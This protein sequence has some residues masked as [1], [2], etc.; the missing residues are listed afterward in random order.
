VAFFD[1]D[2]DGWLDILVLNGSRLDASA[3]PPG[4]SNRLYRN[5]RDGTFTDVTEKAG[6]TR[7]GWAQGVTIGDYNNDGHED[8][9]ITYYG[10]NV[11]YR[12]N[13]DGT[14]T[15]VTKEA[16][17]LH[18]GT[19]WGSGCT[20]IDYN[21]DGHLDLFVANYVDFDVKR[22]GRPGANRG[23]TYKTHPVFCGPRG[24][25]TPH[26]HI[27]RNNG[28]GTF[29]DVTAE[30]FGILEGNNS[31][32]MSAIATDLDNDGWPDIFVACDSTASFYFHNRQNGTFHDD[33]LERGI[34]L[35]ENGQVQAGMGVAV[36]D[37][38]LDGNLDLFKTHFAE[39]T[40]E[41]YRNDGT[42]NFE[43]A[44][45]HAGLGVETRYVSWGAG[46]VDLDND[47]WPDLFFV[48]G[49]PY[50]GIEKKL[51]AM[52]DK[53]PRVIFRNLG[54]GKFE[55]MME[56][57]GPGVYEHHS[58]RGCAFGDFDNDG[59]MDVLIMNMNGP[60]SLLRNDL[61][62]TDKPRH[63]LKVK[64]IGVK[65]NRSAI[66]AR[67][68]AAYG[69]RKQAQEVHAQSSY[70]SVNDSRLHFG[71]GDFDKADLEV[72]WPNGGVEKFAEVPA[73]KLIT[74]REGEGIIRSEAFP[75]A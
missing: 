10:Q 64:L 17:L 61:Q 25:T 69:G 74:I 30:A 3:V 51:P 15:D 2:S 20:F 24:L 52:A 14:F 72:R 36:G 38:N 19:R 55:E 22:V 35:A 53:G 68:T 28:D 16:G 63:W 37:Y 5:N 50:P 44:T 71:L 66:G 56:G 62:K 12:N 4:T 43:V 59:D 60:P 27:Y 47:G 7:Q 73:G 46:I 41:L 75:P 48:T 70:F 9:F 32:A 23:C 21:R 58:S 1:Y 40:N 45:L 18:E 29:R 6:L 42:G 31:F 8:I 39:D 54:N 33:A 13:G 49:S 65:S 34:S 57:A 67:I 11:L 26:Q